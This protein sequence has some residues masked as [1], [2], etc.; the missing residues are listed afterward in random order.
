[1]DL[2]LE[3]GSISRH[4]ANL[5]N[6][7]EGVVWVIDLGSTNGTS[8]HDQPVR[9]WTR[10]LPG[11]VI[12]FGDVR[13][14]LEDEVASTADIPVRDTPPE[15]RHHTAGSEGRA[16]GSGSPAPNGKASAVDRQRD[17]TSVA[18]PQNYLAVKPKKA[19][20]IVLPPRSSLSSQISPPTEPQEKLV[21]HEGEMPNG[22]HSTAGETLAL[23]EVEREA[24]RQVDSLVQ[25]ANALVQRSSPKTTSGP[26]SLD[27]GKRTG[28]Q[29]Y[30]KRPRTEGMPLR[31]ASLINGKTAAVPMPAPGPTR[32]TRAESLLPVPAAVAPAVADDVSGRGAAALAPAPAPAPSPAPA[33]GTVLAPK[34]RTK[35]A[36]EPAPEPAAQPLPPMARMPA[37]TVPEPVAQVESA[38]AIA[39]PQVVEA[40]AVAFY[41]SMAFLA[42]GLFLGF[43][44]GVLVC[45]YLLF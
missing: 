44:A 14:R 8:L 25:R 3:A 40:R 20:G 17:T 36:P 10:V 41:K 7:P 5:H 1:M 33:Q 24:H 31:P 13:V 9:D 2:V 38:P 43:V 22:E 16:A 27:P 11:D 45:K 37:Q 28:Q 26:L 12:T 21:T 30:L 6:S 29:D 23:P 35:P 34:A 42:L 32:S 18:S 15:F 39:G 19:S 4:H